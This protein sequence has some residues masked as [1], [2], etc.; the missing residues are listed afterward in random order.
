MTEDDE[1][2]ERLAELRREL[3]AWD[4]WPRVLPDPPRPKPTRS[5]QVGT[6]FAWTVVGFVGLLLLGVI[7]AGAVWLIRQLVA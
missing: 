7:T 3:D 1:L 5:E 4:Q 6:A 2:E